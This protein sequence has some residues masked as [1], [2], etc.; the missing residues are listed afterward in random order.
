M[1][2]RELARYV[3]LI[4][5]CYYRNLD[6]YWKCVERSDIALDWFECPRDW[7]PVVRVMAQ[8]CSYYGE[9]AWHR[10]WVGQFPGHAG[11]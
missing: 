11:K 1:E 8:G 3:W 9:D 4:E 2:M 10:D 5:E 6:G 7:W